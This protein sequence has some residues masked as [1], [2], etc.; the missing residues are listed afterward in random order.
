VG[1]NIG[2]F[3]LYA[4]RQAPGARFVSI[5]P[6][7]DTA[8]R[9]RDTVQRNA[10][11]HRVRCIELALGPYNHERTIDLSVPGPSQSR[12]LQTTSDKGTRIECVSLATFFEREALDR[13]DMLKMDIEGEE[14]ELL[15]GAPPELLRR[16]TTLALEYHPNG[17]RSRLFAA[18]GAGGFDL[19][20][21]H[22]AGENSGV[23]MFRQRGTAS[24]S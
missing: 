17:S 10:L 13:I 15:L 23:A 19:V 3:T 6:F 21:D 22:P 9:L 20:H 1:A 5:E 24:A 12:N 7:P 14:H 8:A 2:A 11:G 4:A 18:L 16:I